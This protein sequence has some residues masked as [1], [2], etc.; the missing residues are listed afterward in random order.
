MNAKNTNTDEIICC[1][2]IKAARERFQYYGYPKTT[3]AELAHDCDMSPGNIYRYFKGK[4][5]IAA[6]IAREESLA[7]IERLNFVLKHTNISE[8]QRLEEIMFRELKTSTDSLHHNS[9]VVELAQIV[10]TER[11]SFLEEGLYRERQIFVTVLQKGCDK[12][13]FRIKD[14][15]QAAAALQ[16]ATMKFHYPQFFVHQPFIEL[17]QELRNMLDLIFHGIRN[18]DYIHK[19]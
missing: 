1:N 2:I 8:R 16:T 19:I 17:E 13:E 12:G 7:T 14:V 6:E 10:A 11:P 5:D 15:E 9:K 3:M 4:I 18:P